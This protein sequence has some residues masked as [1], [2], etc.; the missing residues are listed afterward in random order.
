MKLEQPFRDEIENH[1]KGCESCRL[2]FEQNEA[3]NRYLNFQ[4]NLVPP[5]SLRSQ[6]LR[7]YH[8]KSR[9]E[10]RLIYL[11]RPLAAAA[12]VILMI[13]AG[14]LSGQ[15]IAGRFLSNEATSDV[16]DPIS[17]YADETF[18]PEADFFTPGF[19]YLNE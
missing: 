2:A 16:A 7:K 13:A 18:L 6:I 15:F 9:T 8:E 17:L 1:L 10:T 19:E 12:I 3:I 5:S 4:K 14:F 11:F